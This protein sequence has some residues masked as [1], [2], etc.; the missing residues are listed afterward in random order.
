L[1]SR[2][3]SQFGMFTVE[4][5]IKGNKAIGMNGEFQFHSLVT[6]CP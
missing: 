6:Q 4:Y 3:A 5:F 2:S 1:F